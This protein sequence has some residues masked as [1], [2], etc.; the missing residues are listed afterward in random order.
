MYAIMNKKTKKFVYGTD[1]RQS[2]K[3]KNSFGYNNITYKQIT[4]KNN[5]MLFEYI[6][7]A[8]HQRKNRGMSKNYVIVEIEIKN[9]KIIKENEIE[10]II[11]K[12]WE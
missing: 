11:D 12:E 2:Y 3:S 8:K 7:N 9:I 10:K 6:E 1:K 5:A 4:S